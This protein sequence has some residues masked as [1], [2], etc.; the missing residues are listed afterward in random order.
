MKQ[1]SFTNEKQNKE[2]IN[3]DTE[4]PSNLLKSTQLIC[5]GTTTRITFAHPCPTLHP[6]RWLYIPED[7]SKLDG[8]I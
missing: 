3:Y 8:H 1:L 7:I 4:K 2:Q 5:L 6:L